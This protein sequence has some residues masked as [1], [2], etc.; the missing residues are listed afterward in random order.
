MCFGV[1]MPIVTRVPPSWV[2]TTLT[3]SS[4]GP[5][6]SLL[7]PAADHEVHRVSTLDVQVQRVLTDATPSRVFPSR[8]AVPVV[9]ARPLP[10]RRCWLH[11]NPTSR[12]CSTRESVALHCRCQLCRARYS[13]G[14]PYLKHR[15]RRLFLPSTQRV[16]DLAGSRRSAPLSSCVTKATQEHTVEAVRPLRAS[17][18]LLA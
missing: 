9:T 1:T 7:H 18:H 10:P 8:V 12:R 16:N 4:T 13:H 14:L 5:C 17:S 6:A 2:L 15:T 11:T 3:A